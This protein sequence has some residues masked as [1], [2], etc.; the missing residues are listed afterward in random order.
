MFGLLAAWAGASFCVCALGS[1]LCLGSALGLGRII[2]SCRYGVI[3]G[4]ICGAGK[5]YP[6]PIFLS[7]GYAGVTP[8]SIDRC[9]L[10]ID[11]YE[12]RGIYFE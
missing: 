11:W 12:R 6:T 3:M 10:N 5:G 2:L 1:A 9:H 7:C 4:V 8:I